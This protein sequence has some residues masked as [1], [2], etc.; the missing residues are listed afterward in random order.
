MSFSHRTLVL[1]LA[2]LWLG[3]ALM[4]TAVRA[5]RKEA[6]PKSSP[7]KKKANDETESPE[8]WAKRFNESLEYKT[9]RID[10]KGGLATLNLP[11]GFRYLDPEQ[12][13]KVLE[14]WGN[15]PG[16]ETLGMLFPKTIG[17]LDENS[18]GVVI[19]FKEDGWVDDSE[20]A[21]IDYADLLTQMQTD[22][23][24]GNEARRSQGYE[25]ITLV[26]WAAPPHYEKATHKLYWAK[27]LKFGEEK[28]H[29]LNYD[30]RVLG[31]KGVLVLNA[32]SSMEQLPLIEK[33]MQAVLGVVEFNA[34]H[35]Y[36]DYKPGADKVAAYGIGALI[37]GKVL[38]KAG[39]F[40][41]LLAILVAGKKLVVV[42]FVAVLGLLKNI[43]GRKS[44]EENQ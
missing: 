44:A 11:D 25:P 18:W 38:A 23:K 29:T 39:F 16:K 14:A 1:G 28:A 5:D 33:D 40:K 10:L 17:P 37:A 3:W 21:K 30:V 15:P 35:T 12:T 26:G 32:V 36:A 43:F 7:T 9:G 13:A 24:A 27:E 8:A 4:G 31:R 34:G 19:S 20:A 42:V 22:I 41:G 2:I 6:K